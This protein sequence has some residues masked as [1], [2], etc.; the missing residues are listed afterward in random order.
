LR[1][2]YL[3]LD[4]RELIQV[5]TDLGAQAAAPASGLL[6]TAAMSATTVTS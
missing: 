2:Q 4:H 5:R 1:Q 3:T 6:R